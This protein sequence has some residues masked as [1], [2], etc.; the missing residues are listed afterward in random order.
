MS[1]KTIWIVM[2][3]GKP[4][5]KWERDRRIAVC[6]VL[7]DEP[8][9]K[10]ISMRARGMREIGREWRAMSSS[11]QTDAGK[12]RSEYWP[13]RWAAEKL[14]SDLNL[15]ADA[16]KTPRISRQKLTREVIS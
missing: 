14:C 10:M 11:A 2:E 4:G 13:A 16:Q 5:G 8:N 1:E 3:S 12:A 9:P 6:R 7:A 15:N